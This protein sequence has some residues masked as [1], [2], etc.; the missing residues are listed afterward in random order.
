MFSIFVDGYKIEKGVQIIKVW[1]LLQDLFGW[2]SFLY[3]KAK[4]LYANKL[5]FD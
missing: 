1:T 5:R 2:Q 3:K 4:I